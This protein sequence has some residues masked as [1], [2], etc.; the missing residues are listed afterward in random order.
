MDRRCSMLVFSFFSLLPRAVVIFAN[1]AASGVPFVTRAAMAFQHYHTN[2]AKHKGTILSC[3][4]CNCFYQFSRIDSIVLL[5]AI[6]R[7][8][9]SGVHAARPGCLALLSFFKF[10]FWPYRF[11]GSAHLLLL[12]SIRFIQPTYL[13]RPPLSPSVTSKRKLPLPLAFD[14]PTGG[15]WTRPRPQ[16]YNS[17]NSLDQ[18]K[19]G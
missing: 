8:P 9:S 3:M 10:G 14:T 11:E 2:Q 16:T 13:L 12:V 18:T 6:C 7:T 5:H 4:A 19:L 15:K 1:G 17:S